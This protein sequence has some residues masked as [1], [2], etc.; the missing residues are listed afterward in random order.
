MPASDLP[1]MKI[2]TL[3]TPRLILRPLTVAD[4]SEIERHVADWDVARWTTSIPHPYPAGA[5]LA[6]PASEGV[7]LPA[8]P[9]WIGSDYRLYKFPSR[10]G[11]R[12]G[13]FG[14]WVAKPMWGRAMRL[15]PRICR[16]RL[17][18]TRSKQADLRRDARKCR[19]HPRAGEG[20]FRKVGEGIRRRRPPDDMF[21]E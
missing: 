10:R 11:R 18:G 16:L 7:V 5:E 8:S 17:Q 2:P 15:R 4:A 3:Q 6:W 9:N 1:G 20:G 14:Y 21:V 13:E 12:S 19:F